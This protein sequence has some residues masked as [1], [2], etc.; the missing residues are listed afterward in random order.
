M[1]TEGDFGGHDAVEGLTS[2]VL[3]LHSTATPDE[4]IQWQIDAFLDALADVALR[5]AERTLASG[6]EGGAA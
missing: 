6:G 1:S 4:V 3:R 2:R 5:V